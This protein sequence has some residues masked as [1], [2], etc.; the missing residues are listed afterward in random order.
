ML[1]HLRRD[2]AVQHGLQE[3]PNGGQG[4]A[5]VVGDIGDELLLVI[6]EGSHCA[7]HVSKGR[8]Q[9]AHLV[10]AFHVQL[11]VHVAGRILFRRCDDP[12][13]RA[14]YDLC[15][16]DQNDQ[17]QEQDDD[18]HQIGDVEHTVCVLVDLR[19]GL[20]YDHIAPCLVIIDDRGY[21]A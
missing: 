9:I 19:G 20:V 12:S 5:E 6:L 2:R 13:K 10:F 11:I 14:V 7:G 1:V 15:E 8:G 21:D 3:T 16:E 18:Q 4:R 17:G